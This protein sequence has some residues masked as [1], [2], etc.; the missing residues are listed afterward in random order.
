M[1]MRGYTVGD[2]ICA[3]QKTSLEINQDR[4]QNRSASQ[5]W[6]NLNV[7]FTVLPDNHVEEID[8]IHFRFT[9]RIVSGEHGNPRDEIVARTVVAVIPRK[10]P[11]CHGHYIL[12]TEDFPVI[13]RLLAKL[14]R[15]NTDDKALKDA[16]KRLVNR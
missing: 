4:C 9:N 7:K 12:L 16:F 2:L 13:G 8:G 15:R 11:G 10:E 6:S 5:Y 3:A 14:Q 1:R